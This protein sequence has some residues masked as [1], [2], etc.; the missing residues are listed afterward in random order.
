MKKIIGIGNA[1]VDI[2]ARIDSDKPLFDL[3]LPKGSMQF[4]TSEQ[5]IEVE[6]VLATLDTTIAAGGSASNTMKT[7]AMLGMETAFISMIGDDEM[8]I[9]FKMALEEQHVKPLLITLQGHPTGIAS[10]FIS[11]DGQRT[12]AD[13]LGAS[14]MLSHTDI[15]A[16]ILDG[17][18]TLYVEGYLV[19][20]H[21]LITT[22]LSWAKEREMTTCLDL[23]SYNVVSAEREFFYHLIEQYID[24]VFANEEESVALTGLEAKEAAK[25]MESL[26]KI[27]VVK[28]GGKGACAYYQGKTSVAPSVH[29]GKVIDTTGAG[30]SFAGGFLY[31]LS[32]EKDMETCLLAGNTVAAEMIQHIGAT[33]HEN[34]WKT[35]KS[36]LHF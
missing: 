4:T 27:A 36:R 20:N 24:I 18:D 33:L 13:N 29:N 10:T 1:L 2:L 26:C 12:F 14:A 8:G 35:I 22:V 23:A 16:D 3:G 11:P 25:V 5:Q 17:Y 32:Q 6:R 34:T 30:D 31:A 15:D 21:D 9:K 19:Q 7:A 28:L